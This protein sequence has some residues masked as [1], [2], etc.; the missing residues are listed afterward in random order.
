MLRD[1]ENVV[2]ELYSTEALSKLSGCT[3]AIDAAEYMSRF[4]HPSPV[5]EPLLSALGGAPFTM[6]KQVA[7]DLDR[8]K[9]LNIT[10]VFYFD[11]LEFGP[12]YTPFEESD[13]SSNLHAQAWKLYSRQ[14]P[15]EAVKT[16]GKSKAFKAKSFAAHFQTMLV[17]QGI[18]YQ[19]AP[20]SAW[21]QVGF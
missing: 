2:P 17:E 13:K 20:Y 15:G 7:D 16:F 11:G 1:L 14:E 6:R 10:P 3:I 12:N 4:L 21:A 18:E 9:K 8:L 19:I 5:V